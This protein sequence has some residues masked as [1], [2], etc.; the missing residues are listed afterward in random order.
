MRYINKVFRWTI[1]VTLA[2]S[3]K[4]QARSTATTILNELRK[5]RYAGNIARRFVH[6]RTIISLSTRR[7]SSV[8]CFD[9][10]KIDERPVAFVLEKQDRS[11]DQEEKKRIEQEI[12]Q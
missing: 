10:K 9:K 6:Q 11:D 7:C 12:P 2:K 5:R 1:L 4:T 8:V 3:L